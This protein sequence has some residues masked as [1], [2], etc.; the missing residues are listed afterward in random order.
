MDRNGDK[1]AGISMQQQAGDKEKVTSEWG[2]YLRSYKLDQD[3]FP[4]LGL[5]TA[6]ETFYVDNRTPVNT[7]DSGLAIHPGNWHMCCSSYMDSTAAWGVS[8]MKLQD[9][10][11]GVPNTDPNRAKPYTDPVPDGQC[12]GG[13]DSTVNLL[14]LHLRQ[15]FLDPGMGASEGEELHSVL[16]N[17]L[18]VWVL[19]KDGSL[20]FE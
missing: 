9:W 20:P 8:G 13:H 18:E 4:G 10:L 11:P 1:A 2:S 15:L 14:R 17:P 5:A 3:I 7:T 16:E 6:A 19:E 12:K